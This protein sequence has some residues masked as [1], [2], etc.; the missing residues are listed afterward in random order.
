MNLLRCFTEARPKRAIDGD[1]LEFP[2]CRMRKQRAADVANP[3]AQRPQ[4][5]QFLGASMDLVAANQHE[6]NESLVRNR[7]G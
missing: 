7:L 2:P 6:E 5:S 3:S 1:Q 4:F